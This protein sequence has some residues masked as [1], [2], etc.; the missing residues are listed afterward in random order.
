MGKENILSGRRCCRHLNVGKE[1]REKM[2]KYKGIIFDL[3]GTLLNTIEDLGNSVNDVLS[4][5]KCPLHNEAE[6]KQL[7]GNG[8]LNLLESSF[9]NEV[10]EEIDMEEA[11]AKFQ[12]AYDKRYMENTAPYDGIIELLEWLSKKGV[13]IGVNSNKRDEYTKI[14]VKKFFNHIPF[15]NVCGEQNEVPR[16]PDPTIALQIA[17]QM[18]EDPRDLLYIGDSKVDMKTGENAGMD[19]VGVLWGFRDRKELEANRATYVAE[20]IMDIMELI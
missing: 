14:L 7:V 12:K 10:L 3:D 5:Y 1:R 6:Y 4:E 17:E 11:Y 15:V 20:T 9:P 13:K 18:E 16:K 8:M 2:K 19:T